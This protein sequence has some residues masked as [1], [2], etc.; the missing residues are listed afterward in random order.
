MKCNNCGSKSVS[1]ARLTLFQGAEYL[2]NYCQ[3]CE[4]VT[5][6]GGSVPDASAKIKAR[7]RGTIKRKRKGGDK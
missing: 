6:M 2:V 4:H 1:P 7:F 3:A 5:R